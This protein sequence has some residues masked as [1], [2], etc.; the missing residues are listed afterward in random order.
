MKL[1]LFV[2]LISLGFSLTGNSARADLILKCGSFGNDA[3][4]RPFTLNVTSSTLK[5][6]FD[7][8]GESSTANRVRTSGP[9]VKY[10]HFSKNIGSEVYA[11]QTVNFLSTAN[12]IAVPLNLRTNPILVRFYDASSQASWSTASCAKL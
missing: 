4:S 2:T 11:G 3:N 5:L 12:T 1:F 6:T 10:T 7:A 9:V 8:S